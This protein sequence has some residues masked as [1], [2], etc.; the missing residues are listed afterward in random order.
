MDPLKFNFQIHKYK[1]GHQL[2]ESTIELGRTDQD[3]IDRL[4]DLSGQLRPGELF[5]PYFTCY[6]LPS[7]KQFVVARTWQDL[8]AARAG[9]VL[10]KSVIIPMNE[11]EN[12]IHIPLVFGM[13]LTSESDL[14]LPVSDF[15][16]DDYYSLVS[17][18]P[19][20]ELVEALFLEQR[21]PILIIDGK[22]KNQIIIRLYSV[23]WPSMRRKFATCTFALSARTINNR[24]FDLLFTENALRNRF[25]DWTGRR[26]EGAI[27]DRKAARHRWTS[28]L[29]FRIFKTDNPSLYKRDGQSPFNF[30]SSGDE[31]ILRLSL[32]WDE[33]FKKATTESSPMAILGLLDIIN[34]QPSISQHLYQ[35]IEPQIKN[36]ISSALKSLSVEDAWKFYG[37]LLV[38]H[39]R[40]LM[41]R[42]MLYDVK[43]SCTLLTAKSPVSA[44]EFILNY[45]PSLEKIPSI[46]YAA[47]G[48]GIAQSFTATNKIPLEKI[49]N[50]LGLLLLATS[51]NFASLFMALLQSN[52]KNVNE[53]LVSYFKFP[54]SK[55]L[56]RAK[57]NLLP[58][59]ETPAHRPVFELQIQNSSMDQYKKVLSTVAERTHL[60]F[61]DF[62]DLILEE[63]IYKNAADYLLEVLIGIGKID[64]LVVKL[65]QLHPELIKSFFLDKRLSPLIRDKILLGI[66]NN[67]S[68]EF[69]SIL[70][71]DK[72]F[73][74]DIFKFFLR[75][76]NANRKAFADFI[77]ITDVNTDDAINVFSDLSE[78]IVNTVNQENLYDLLEK[79]M[80]V[81]SLK[82]S[83]GVII[84]KF[85]QE[86]ADRYLNHFF[87]STT[88]EKFA[89]LIFEVLSSLRSNIRQS[90]VN[91]IDVISEILAANLPQ[92][93]S[94]MLSENWISLLK[95]S[96]N[97]DKQRSAAANMLEFAFNCKKVDPSNLIAVSFPIV[98]KTYLG[99]KSVAQKI[100]FWIFSDWDKCKTLRYSLV[101]HYLKSNWSGIGLFQV[102]KNTGITNEVISILTETKVGKK[103]LKEAM[104][105]MG[106]NTTMQKSLSKQLKQ[107]KK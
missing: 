32:L 16:K 19:I 62:N 36:A 29:S 23:F 85:N 81:T 6:P 50:K 57:N 71:L 97:V 1:N 3:T 102:A 17:E 61:D 84:E 39:K 47:I 103:F 28:D 9:C 33:L 86:N 104:K 56:Q 82:S 15:K 93:F 38:K 37:G 24:L 54:D 76:K 60:K 73:S 68:Y 53:I 99:G 66:I 21:K 89:T 67:F 45:N 42:E 64:S 91:E 78:N 48:D 72:S 43:S 105:E 26:I 40:K 96:N 20:E 107:I 80:V 51:S 14:T 79:G 30:F 88:E 31:S 75:N 55:A 90:L 35:A 41:G 87:V 5:D 10:T 63:T 34:S 65:L 4:S 70:S 77:L 74:K 59:I 8:T 98:Y 25:S 92:D 11:W 44:I 18:A 46:L 13:L 27:N 106:A 83:I 95:I 101:E 2:V 7:E 100:S 12:T 94:I 58:L 22:E 69:L 49:P 52:L